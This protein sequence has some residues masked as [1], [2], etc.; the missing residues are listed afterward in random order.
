MSFGCSSRLSGSC[1][2]EGISHLV[3]GSLF[4]GG[5]SQGSSC[6]CGASLLLAERS[7]LG[8]GGAGGGSSLSGRLSTSTSAGDASFRGLNSRLAGCSA[9]L[10]SASTSKSHDHLPVRHTSFF[11]RFSAHYFS[12]GQRTRQ[13]SPQP[14][15]A[16]AFS[17]M[18]LLT[19]LLARA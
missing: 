6:G 17:L 13:P 4:D 3:G 11:P 1:V 8:G 18:R 19:L 14:N 2:S 5:S 7:M 15:L 16:Q 12:C 9:R 10:A